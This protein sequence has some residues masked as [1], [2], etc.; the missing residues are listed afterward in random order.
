MIAEKTVQAGFAIAALALLSLA[1]PSEARAASCSTVAEAQGIIQSSS[2]QSAL[3]SA[4]GGSVPSDPANCV[5]SLCAASA[6]ESPEV[7][8]AVGAGISEA[9]SQ[10]AGSD[11]DE[12]A[13]ALRSSAC[14]LSCNE[15]IVTA[16]A[17][18][19]A[20]S[21]ARLCEAG[22]GGTNG[23]VGSIFQVDAGGGGGGVSP[24]VSPQ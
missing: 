1:S 16:F 2:T 4:V 21:V 22:Y 13:A 11:N 12:G 5:P 8:V 7:Q 19:Q 9:Y 24:S 23:V 18:S 10:L 20:T 14:S 6:D 3:V 17:A 15:T